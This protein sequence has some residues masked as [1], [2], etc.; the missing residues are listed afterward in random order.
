MSCTAPCVGIGDPL[1]QESFI[2]GL[3]AYRPVSLARVA[4]MLLVSTFLWSCGGKDTGNASTSRTKSAQTADRSP[5]GKLRLRAVGRLP[6]PLQL[7]SA[8][9]LPDGRTLV[10]GGLSKVDTSTNAIFRVDPTG[11]ARVVGSLPGPLHDSAASAVEGRAYLFGGGNTVEGSAILRITESGAT[12]SAGKLP[13]PASDVAAATVGPRAYIVGG[14]TGVTPLRSILAF[15]PGSP[16]RK[17][18]SLPNP[19]RYAAVASVGGDLLI[20]GGTAGTTA[21]RSILRFRPATGEV[22]RIG[23]L[24]QPLTHAAAAGLGGRFYVLGGRGSVLN[25]ASSAIWSVDPATG[26]VTA[27]GRLPTGLSDLAAV[28]ASNRI[29]VLG[30]RTAAGRVTDQ[31]L[32]TQPA[33]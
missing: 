32:A 20:A 10:L 29:L 30:G 12:S 15:S 18:A 6:V 16:V 26:K 22:K 14:Y 33:G 4:A 3:P 21:Q 23:S 24:P 19:L 8:V 2:E 13:V 7:P 5:A 17:V 31:I 1:I 9:A 27:A 11:R 25:S 28:A